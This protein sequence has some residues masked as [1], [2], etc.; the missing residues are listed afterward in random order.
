MKPTI[1]QVVAHFGL[2]DRAV[3][4]M[5]VKLAIDRCREESNKEDGFDSVKWTFMC[6]W[7][8]DIRDWFEP[9]YGM[10]DRE[11]D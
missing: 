7:D 1:E 4:S 5:E 6:E 11:I 2:P 10:A 8:C 3:E 9:D